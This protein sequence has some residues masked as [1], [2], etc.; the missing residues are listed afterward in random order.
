M[1]KFFLIT[2]TGFIILAFDKE[3]NKKNVESHNSI[4]I[5]DEGNMY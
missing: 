5:D 4:G 3:E 1:R 2:L